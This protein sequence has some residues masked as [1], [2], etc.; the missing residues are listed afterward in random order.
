MAWCLV[1]HRDNLTFTFD[2][3]QCKESLSVMIYNVS[4]VNPFHAIHE[5]CNLEALDSLV[6][7]NISEEACFAFPRQIKLAICGL[8]NSEL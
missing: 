5:L 3:G 4:S 6:F 8:S 1:K 7:E 2:D